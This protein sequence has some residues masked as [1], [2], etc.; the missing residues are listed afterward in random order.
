MRIAF[1]VS[2][3]KQET[4]KLKDAYVAVRS[5]MY[6]LQSREQQPCFRPDGK[7]LQKRLGQL[8]RNTLRDGRR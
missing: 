3:C 5:T 2:G 1:P 4:Q 8:T 7:S 6:I